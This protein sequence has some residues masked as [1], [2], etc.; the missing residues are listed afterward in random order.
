MQSV[1]QTWPFEGRTALVTGAASGIGRALALALAEAGARLVL[2]DVQAA[3]LDETARQVQT[4]GADC[5]AQPVDVAD[6]REVQA[7]VA[8]AS[9]RVGRIE[10][11]ANAAA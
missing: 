7:L 5:L 1:A 4:L 3:A 2:G 10:L 11:L 9:T 8:L 6:E